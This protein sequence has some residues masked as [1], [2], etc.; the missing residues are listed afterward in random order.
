MCNVRSPPAGE[1][2][3]ASMHTVNLWMG[4]SGVMNRRVTF[5]WTR[6]RIG[7][8]QSNKNGEQNARGNQR[9]LH[10]TLFL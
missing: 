10:I 3:T 5:V 7:W 4:I 8:R 2:L 6:L 9:L 1:V